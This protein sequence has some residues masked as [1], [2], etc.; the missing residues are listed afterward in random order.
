MFNAY[1]STVTLSVK[2]KELPVW[3]KGA[4]IRLENQNIREKAKTFALAKSTI[5]Y[6]LSKTECTE[7]RR[8]TV[9]VPE[10]HKKTTV[11]KK[12]KKEKNNPSQ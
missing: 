12:K 2:S 4:I 7:E 8:K 9:K 3:V 5:W 6:F 11:Q 10:D 1:F